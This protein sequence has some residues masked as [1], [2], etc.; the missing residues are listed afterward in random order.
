[1]CEG[2]KMDEKELKQDLEVWRVA[3][4]TQMHFNDLLIK[5]RTTVITVALA[6]IGATGIML[7]EAD[8]YF[9]ICRQKVHIG[10]I[11][12]IVGVIFL[13][14]Q[15][16]IDYCYYFKLLLGAVNFTED[17]DKKYPGRQFGLTTRISKS[18]PVWKAKIFLVT[19]YLI[20][21]VLGIILILFIMFR[22]EAA[23][24]G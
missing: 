3:V 16:I 13:I 11:I 22:M 6:V 9:N 10:V 18:V 20:P 15:F 21:I 12:L 7:K 17:M 19:F 14:G 2:K 8:I 4:E 23:P 24:C 1:M 5:S